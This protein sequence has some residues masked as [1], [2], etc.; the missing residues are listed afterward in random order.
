MG[1]FRRGVALALTSFG[2]GLL[3]CAREVQVGSGPAWVGDVGPDAASGLV[4]RIGN[5]PFTRTV[6]QDAS[7]ETA[8]VVAGAYEVEL[9]RLA[10]ARVSATGRFAESEEL[11]RYLDAT[12]YEILAVDDERPHTGTLERTEEGFVLTTPGGE[13]IPLAALSESLESAVGARVWV[14][15]DESRNV[16]RYGILRTPEEMARLEEERPAGER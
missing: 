1:R 14:T 2:L 3:G 5:E 16:I 13:V 6:I 4:R 8:V 15:L 9:G 11:G 7:S 10:G 12:S